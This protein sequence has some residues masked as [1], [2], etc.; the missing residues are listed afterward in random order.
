[1]I[2]TSTTATSPAA[3]PEQKRARFVELQSD[4][5]RHYDVTAVSRFVDIARPP[6][7]VHVL[8][9][10]AGEPVLYLHGGDGEA[11]DWMPLVARLQRH[12]RLVGVDRPGFGL[13]DRFDYSSVD[14]R[15]HAGAFVSSLLDSLGIEQATIMGGSMG[16]FFAL[17]AALDYPSRVKRLVLTGMA[18]GLTREASPELRQLCGVP[19]AAQAFVEHSAN[20]EA[21]HE[22]YRHMFNVDPATIPELYFETRLAGLT[23]PGS[24]DTWALLLT[25][26]ADLDGFKPEIYLGNDLAQLRA[27]VLVLWG[28]H[29]MAPLAVA[30]D[31]AAR[32]PDCTLIAMD[33]VGHFPFLERPEATAEAIL[34][35]LG[36]HS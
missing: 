12:V 29:D 32:I 3:S 20:L 21:Q 28:D 24:Q 31:A 8:D 14:L 6:M 26:L 36:R 25:R 9:A 19:G 18:V 10:G 15:T 13:S 2:T 30:R 17:C 7:R 22:Q 27:P 34:E 33:G 23:L 35:F 5:I 1:M 16:G 4:L 11:V